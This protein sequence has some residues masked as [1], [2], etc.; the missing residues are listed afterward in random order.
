MR[1]PTAIL[2]KVDEYTKNRADYVHCLG[3]VWRILNSS[4]AQLDARLL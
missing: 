4:A 2:S 3:S 1:R